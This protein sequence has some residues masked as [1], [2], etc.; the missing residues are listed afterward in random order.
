MVLHSKE[1]SEDQGYQNGSV[2]ET[3]DTKPSSGDDLSDTDS[4]VESE[5]K[6]TIGDLTPPDT[7]PC[8]GES[9]DSDSDSWGAPSNSPEK[10]RHVEPAT[11]RGVWWCEY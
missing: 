5:K 6:A 10:G 8:D 3:S 7:Q 11:N 9:V 4:G 2:L 1:D